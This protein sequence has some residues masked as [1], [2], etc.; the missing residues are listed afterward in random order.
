MRREIVAASGAI[1]AE[2][3][4]LSA[5]FPGNFPERNRIISGL[6]AGVVVIEATVR[7][8]TLITARMALEQGREVMAVPGSVLDGR[9]GGCHRLIKQGAALVE[10]AADVLEASRARTRRGLRAEMAVP[11]NPGLASVLTAVPSDV[12]TSLHDIVESLGKIG[13]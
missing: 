9:H 8:G 2:Y 7:S 13:A 5:S 6:S 10:S 12:E 11:S 3:P 1:V 4:P